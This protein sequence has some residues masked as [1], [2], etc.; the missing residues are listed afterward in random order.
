M[1]KRKKRKTRKRNKSFNPKTKKVLMIV[2]IVLVLA[3]VFSTVR[4]ITYLKL[5]RIDPANPFPVKGIDV[6]KYQGKIDWDTIED[7]D[8][9]FAFIKAT[10]G[11]SHVDSMFATHWEDVQDTDIRAGAYHFL[12]YDS[13]GEAQAENFISNVPSISHML[14]PVVDVEFYGK[15]VATAL[16]PTPDAMHS[17]LTPL[18]ESLED[19]YGEKPVIYTN[20]FIYDK[21]ISGTYDD[22]DIWIS[23]LEFIPDA[24]A[25]AE[26]RRLSDGR[27]WAFCQYS[28]NG[29]LQSSEKGNTINV[30]LNVFQ[31]SRW[32]FRKY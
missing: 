15:Y 17:I 9:S 24:T 28:F 27:T 20:E 11:S 16:H 4:G 5:S 18:L 21:Y 13:S 6:S 14:P 29:K 25:T 2:M 1:T 8:V 31:G 3:A 12:S 26:D 19:E 30:D 7:Q 22:Y 10:E 32:D 23:R